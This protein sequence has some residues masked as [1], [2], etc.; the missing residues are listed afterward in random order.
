MPLRIPL[1]ALL[2]PA[3]LLAAC[4]QP[5]DAPAD[6]TGDP[7]TPAVEPEP[8]DDTA[9][10][11]IGTWALAEHAG[12]LPAF[13]STLTFEAD[14]GYVLRDEDGTEQ[15]RTW[16]AVGPGRIEV[17]GGQGAAGASPG[18]PQAEHYAYEVTG[19]TLTLTIAGT[20]AVTTFERVGTRP[21]ADEP[22]PVLPGS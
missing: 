8:P 10:D 9:E 14:G 11:L 1:P 19:N 13:S 21:A 17:T 5:A 7:A 6:R 16:R 15:R 12:A 4:A 20:E 22:E 3:L 2:L 18:A